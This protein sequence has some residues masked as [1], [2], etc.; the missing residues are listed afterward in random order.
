[1]QA[2]AGC[3]PTLLID[4]TKSA[5]PC[6][7]EYCGVSFVFVEIK[8]KMALANV[9]Q[10]S[11]IAGHVILFILSLCIVVPLFINLDQFW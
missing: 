7:S 6:L 5:L 4:N 9:L 10:L 1:M 11:Q 2:A 8:S 3:C